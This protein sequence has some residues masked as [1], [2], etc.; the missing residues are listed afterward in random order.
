M[1]IVHVLAAAVA[2]AATSIQSWSSAV[3]LGRANRDAACW[4]GAEDELVAGE[5]LFRRRAARRLLKVERGQELHREIR[6]IELTLGSWVALL[7]V[8]VVALVE[9]VTGVGSG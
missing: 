7:A 5:R 2:V 3:E 4:M 6:R 9:A 1:N 8:A